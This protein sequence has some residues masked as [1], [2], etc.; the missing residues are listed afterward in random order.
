MNK[1]QPKDSRQSRQPAKEADPS[2]LGREQLAN[3]LLRA[4]DEIFESAEALTVFDRRAIAGLTYKPEWG[5]FEKF[6][7]R[8]V[9]QLYKEAVDDDNVGTAKKLIY[10]AT[11]L[12]KFPKSFRNE[13]SM[14][15]GKDQIQAQGDAAI[16]TEI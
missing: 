2:W 12:I 3:Q 7:N 4:Y 6:I 10:L 5:A 11:S 14:D 13:K 15:S 8:K 9:L 1:Q 16:G